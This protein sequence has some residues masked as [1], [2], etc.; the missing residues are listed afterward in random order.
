VTLLLRLESPGQMKIEILVTL[1]GST[2]GWQPALQYLC[3]ITSRAV[4]EEISGG[5]ASS[6]SA[7]GVPEDSNL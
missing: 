3:A 7:C 6:S 5:R 4:S 2:A 1:D